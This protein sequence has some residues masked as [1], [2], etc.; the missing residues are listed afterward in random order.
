MF[1]IKVSKQTALSSVEQTV[2]IG[3]DPRMHLGDRF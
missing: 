1:T 3:L 2:N